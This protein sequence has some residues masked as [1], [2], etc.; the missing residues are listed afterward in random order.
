MAERIDVTLAGLHELRRRIQRQ[1][2]EAGD[3]PLFG[4][5]VSK[6]IAR[7]EARQERMIAKIAAAAAGAAG[8]KKDASGPVLDAEYAVDDGGSSGSNRTE[9][10]SVEAE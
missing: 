4:A 6:L 8:A 10:S 9:P 7:T 2:L 5:L 1:Q 3:W